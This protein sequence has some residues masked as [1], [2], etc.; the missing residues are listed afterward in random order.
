MVLF[1]VPVNRTDPLGLPQELSHEII[2][3]LQLDTQ[4]LKHCSLVCRSW[5]F[6]SR[7]HLFR[8]LAFTPKNAFVLPELITAPPCSTIPPHVREIEFQDVGHLFKSDYTNSHFL[9]H[10][11]STVT[12]LRLRD[13]TFDNF[14]CVVDIICSFPYLQCLQLN[15]VYWGKSKDVQGRN[16]ISRLLPLSV[17]RLELKNTDLQQFTSWLLSHPNLPA[18]PHIDIGPFEQKDI[19]CAGKYMSLI[20][21]AITRLSY[22]FATVEIEHM[23]LFNI[24]PHLKL[25]DKPMAPDLSGTP[26][27]ASQYKLCF[28]LHICEHL[29]TFINLRYLRIDGFMD[30]TSPGNTTATYW[31]PRILASIKSYCLEHILLGLTLSRA[32]DVDRY[33]VNWAYFDFVLSH[34]S[35]SDLR[36][37]EFEVAGRAQLDSVA[38]L[39]ALR[40]P[41]V[42][43]LGIL[44]FSKAN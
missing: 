42:S 20:G 15:H 22:F 3:H 29:A 19:P 44:H 23:C 33:N 11:S 10:F 25:Q 27:P 26:T 32:G 8:E 1:F 43:G 17:T 31:A 14:Q 7:I 28:G 6:A 21:P 37:V 30:A 9:C 34:K 41:E 39:L 36:I 40:L 2:D 24:F 4:S 13:I 38:N 35:Y 18:I 16:N 5:L 12:H